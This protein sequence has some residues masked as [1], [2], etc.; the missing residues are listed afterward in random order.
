M[1]LDKETTIL[2]D[3]LESYNKENILK[4]SFETG[5]IIPLLDVEEILEIGHNEDEIGEE[6]FQ[7]FSNLM[8]KND[9]INMYSKVEKFFEKYI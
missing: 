9:G 1:V 7:D 6:M 3:R 4:L 8:S 2:Q 5:D